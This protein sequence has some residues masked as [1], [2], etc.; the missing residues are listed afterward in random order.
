MNWLKIGKGVSKGSILS[1]R[2]FNLYAEYIMQNSGLDEA[3]VGVKTAR[4]ISIASSMK[5][6]PPLGQKAK[7]N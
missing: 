4:E 6:T 5:M 3:Q 1:P 2:L 7:M